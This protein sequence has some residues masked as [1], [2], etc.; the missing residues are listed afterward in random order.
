VDQERSYLIRFLTPSDKL[1]QISLGHADF[2]PLKIFAK[3][4]ALA[5]HNQHLARTY[6]LFQVTERDEVF[7]GY[8][9]LV[10]GEVSVE[11]GQVPLEDGTKFSYKS[12]PAVK[13][14]RLAIDQRHRSGGL[15]GQLVSFALG[16]VK[17]HICPRI[18]CR[19]MVVDSKKGSVSFYEKQGFTL[20]DTEENRGSS[21]PVMFLDLWKASK[22]AAVEAS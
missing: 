8:I 13:I 16:E 20:I 15:G 2:A 12:Y 11:P 5:F 9:T 3:R 21:N 17:A 10:S 7:A 1:G 22:A 19:L 14:A 4:H 18:G 6:G